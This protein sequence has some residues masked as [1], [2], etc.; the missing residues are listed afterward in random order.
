MKV[1]IGNKKFIDNKYT[2]VVSYHID[3]RGLYE[4][5]NSI[6]DIDED[7]RH[8]VEF[9]FKAMASQFVLLT[10]E[11]VE[12]ANSEQEMCNVIFFAKI[13]KTPIEESEC[14]TNKFPYEFNWN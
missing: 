8:Y 6:D 5:A 3:F 14:F 4:F 7:E 1:T 12:K 2:Y 13:I 10:N 11:M 9:P